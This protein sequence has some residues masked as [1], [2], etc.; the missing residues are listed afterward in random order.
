MVCA[1]LDLE[2]KCRSLPMLSQR[3]K[4]MFQPQACCRG[5]VQIPS[6]SDQV[7]Y[8]TDPDR[9]VKNLAESCMSRSQYIP[10]ASSVDINL[11]QEYHDEVSSSL[12]CVMKEVMKSL[13]TNLITG[14]TN[15]S[16]RS[17]IVRYSHADQFIN[18]IAQLTSY[19]LRNLN[20]IH[21]DVTSDSFDNSEPLD[22]DYNW[23]KNCQSLQ[24]LELYDWCHMTRLKS[25]L[26]NLPNSLT[27]IDIP[28]YDSFEGDEC[29]GDWD[30][31]A[32]RLED[33][34]FLPLLSNINY[35][36]NSH[37]KLITALSL[38]HPE[39]GNYRP[40]TNLELSRFQNFDW[41]QAVQKLGFDVNSHDLSLLL[42]QP[43]HILPCLQELNIQVSFTSFEWD[44]SPLFTFASKR[45]ITNLGV[46]VESDRDI[47]CKCV[48]VGA[49]RAIFSMNQLNRLAL[50][51]KHLVFAGN[52]GM[53]GSRIEIPDNTLPLLNVLTLKG[54]IGD[55]AITC[56]IKAAPNTELFF[57]SM[58]YCLQNDFIMSVV[59]PHC[60]VSYLV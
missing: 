59:P 55:L 47:A 60:K 17:L 53:F 3:L 44:P 8:D 48:T 12:N 18:Q 11:A 49:T 25:I 37:D 39:T 41:C 29:E 15:G 32:K 38:V 26:L 31:F 34:N 14:I 4:V 43:D 19:Q 52:H 5:F 46:K 56:L 27:S 21:F 2:C 51:F 20:T 58:N 22:F 45:S 24:T 1:Y 57:L 50:G 30:S 36:D 35:F 54:E 33:L 23:L 7:N 16:I 42:Q 6:A 10:F 9:F 28:F 40:I 13:I